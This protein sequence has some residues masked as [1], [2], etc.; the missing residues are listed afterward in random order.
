MREIAVP[1]YAVSSCHWLF[2]APGMDLDVTW[3][4]SIR[5]VKAQIM[6]MCWRIVPKSELELILVF[7]I[8]AHENDAILMGCIP[9]A[10]RTTPNIPNT[11]YRLLPGLA[12]CQ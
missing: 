1:S 11:V 4:T 5:E 7:K 3:M 12:Y 9:N 10:F 2:G 6:A 8:E